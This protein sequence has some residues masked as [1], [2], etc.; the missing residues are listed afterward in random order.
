MRGSLIQLLHAGIS[1]RDWS[2]VE[3][4]ANRLRDEIDLTTRVL[5]GT[6]IGSLPNDYPLSKLAEDASAPRL[7]YDLRLQIG[8]ALDRLVCDDSTPEQVD[9]FVKT[10]AELGLTISLTAERDRLRE[11][12]TRLR[13]T[14]WRL[15]IA[16]NDVDLGRSIHNSRKP[17]QLIEGPVWDILREASAAVRAALSP[18][19]ESK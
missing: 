15:M 1:R 5:A 17:D 14:S 6:A 13:E 16:A 11:E 10:F 3:T 19:E 2:A 4:A 8:K 9:Q 18:V 12:N 7:P